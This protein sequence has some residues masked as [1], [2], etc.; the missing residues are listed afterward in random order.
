MVVVSVLVGHTA[1]HRLPERWVTLERPV[2]VDESA[3]R[4]LIVSGALVMLM[5]LVPRIASRVRGRSSRDARL[6][7]TR[8]VEAPRTQPS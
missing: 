4:A 5:L 6:D 7:G 1:W 3:R 8:P 2:G